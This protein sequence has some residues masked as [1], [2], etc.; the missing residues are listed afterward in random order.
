MN[1]AYLYVRMVPIVVILALLVSAP[2]QAITLLSDDFTYA[3]S[4]LIGNSGGASYGAGTQWGGAWASSTE[5][6]VSPGDEDGW[7]IS[8]N[9]VNTY[10]LLGGIGGLSQVV[11]RPF[12]ETRSVGTYYFGVTLRLYAGG[13]STADVWGM[14]VDKSGDPPGTGADIS[15]LAMPNGSGGW[16]LHGNVT[17]GGVTGS[18]V[19][20]EGLYHRVVG[21]LEWDGNGSNEVLTLWV[22]P[23]LESDTPEVVHNTYDLGTLGYAWDRLGIFGRDIYRE[24]CW[25]LDSMNMTTDFAS[26]RDAVMTPPVAGDVNGDGWVGGADISSIVTNWGMTSAGRT[27][28]DLS[29]NG[30]VGVADYTEVFNTWGTGTPPSEPPLEPIPEPSTMVLLAAAVLAGLI[31]RR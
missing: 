11:D 9:Q 10:G 18:T 1:T 19:L 27:D 13:T 21:R 26:A 17:S 20:T 28:G 24:P 29:E 4:L 2:S 14:T 8:G 22:N 5:L 12:T 15:I 23:T 30:E 31:R 7:I 16:N 3:D 25:A 6:P